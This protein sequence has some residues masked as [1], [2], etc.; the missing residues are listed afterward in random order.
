MGKLAISG[1]VSGVG[2]ELFCCPSTGGFKS[3]R[4]MAVPPRQDGPLHRFLK[5]GR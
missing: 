4:A 5:R 3:L 1:M 2:E